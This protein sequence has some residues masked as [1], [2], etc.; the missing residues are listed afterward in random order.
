[1]V[2]VGGGGGAT[3]CRQPTASGIHKQIIPQSLIWDLK[4]SP[5]Q[6]NQNCFQPSESLPDNLLEK[7]FHIKSEVY[8]AVEEGVMDMDG[9]A[10]NLPQSHLPSKWSRNGQG[11]LYRVSRFCLALC[12]DCCMEILV[13]SIPLVYDGNR[14]LRFLY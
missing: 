9:S 10:T 3:T 14:F 13:S 8:A 12:L 4:S 11:V 1:M 6:T 2:V 5:H 7:M